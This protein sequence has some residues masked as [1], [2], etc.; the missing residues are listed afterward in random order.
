MAMAEAKERWKPTEEEIKD[1]L[2]LLSGEVFGAEKSGVVAVGQ[3]ID[4]FVGITFPV[5]CGIDGVGQVGANHAELLAATVFK[6]TNDKS[7][8]AH[9]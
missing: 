7:A 3:A 9:R 8:I 6:T 5:S 4:G 1:I 2:E